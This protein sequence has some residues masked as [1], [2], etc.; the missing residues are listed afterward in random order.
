MF[1]GTD[2][3]EIERI[4]TAISRSGETFLKRMLT[5]TEVLKVGEECTC[6][7]V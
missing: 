4:K 1:V 7:K 6:R 2:I 5:D 3:V